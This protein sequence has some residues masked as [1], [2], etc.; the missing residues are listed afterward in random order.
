MYRGADRNECS[1]PGHG[2]SDPGHRPRPPRPTPPRDALAGSPGSRHALRPAA[3]GIDFQA[4]RKLRRPDVMRQTL[5]PVTCRWPFLPPLAL[6]PRDLD[7]ETLRS[8]PTAA[9]VRPPTENRLQKTATGGVGK[10]RCRQNPA[11]VGAAAPAPPPTGKPAHHLTGTL[12]A[13]SAPRGPSAGRMSRLR[14]RMVGIVQDK[15]YERHYHFPPPPLRSDPPRG[16]PP[17]SGSGRTQGQGRCHETAANG[18]N[19]LARN[20]DRRRHGIGTPMG[21]RR[22]ST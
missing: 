5:C 9:R 1:I 16:D 17:G 6:L 4:W 12:R 15:R 8:D 20:G 2:R 13:M 21:A 18:R 3:S 11:A 10:G 7:G 22:A 19:I 14:L